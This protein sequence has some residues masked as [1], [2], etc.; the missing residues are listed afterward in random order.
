[1][2]AGHHGRPPANEQALLDTRQKV[3]RMAGDLAC[4]VE[5]D[6][7]PLLVDEQGV[8]ALDARV[9]LRRVLPGEGSWLAFVLIR[10]SWKRPSSW[11]DASC[12][13]AR[14]ALKM[15]SG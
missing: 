8:L 10:R 2:L 3:S 9:R 5:L 4:L 14:S 11:P 7:N 12:C 15:A 6:I 13:C 1:M